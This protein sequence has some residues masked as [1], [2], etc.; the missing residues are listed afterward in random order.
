MMLFTAISAT[1]LLIIAAIS[2]A[3]ID[4]IS[5]NYYKSVFK[6]LKRPGY[7]NPDW[8]WRNK[9]KFGDKTFGEKFKYSTTILV[10]FT[11][12]WHLFKMI[13]KI[14]LMASLLLIGA[15]FGLTVYLLPMFIV[16]KIIHQ[17]VFHVF[18]TYI[19]RAKL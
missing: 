11:D 12:A 14:T 18:Y 6:Y 19:L 13:S 16:S 9:Y 1:I 17:S 2:E 4:I 3:I 8:S 7:W 10:S 15:Q 5:H